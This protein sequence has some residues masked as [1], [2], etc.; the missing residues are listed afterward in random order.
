[1]AKQLK[2]TTVT[3]KHLPLTQVKADML[4]IGL[5]K[6]TKKLPKEFSS[7]DSAAGRVISNLLKLGDFTGKAQETAVLYTAGQLP[8]RRILIVGLGEEQS[9]QLNTLR[10]SAGTAARTSDKLGT[11]KIALA[12]HTLSKNK[13]DLSNVGQAVTEGIIIGHYDFDDYLPA[14]GKPTQ[15][16]KLTA[17]IVDAGTAAALKL[18]AGCKIGNITAQAQNFSRMIANKPGN[19]INPVTLTQQAK[20]IAA[21]TGLRC[22]IFDE[23][24]LAKMKMNALLAVGSGSIHKSRLIMLEHLGRHPA[25]I[26]DDVELD[27]VLPSD[28][29]KQHGP[30][31]LETVQR[32]GQ[33]VEDHLLD[34]LRI[35]RHNE[36]F[37]RFETNVPIAIATHVADHID[38]IIDQL[39]Q[40]NR[41]ASRILGT[42]EIE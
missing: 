4:V 28:Q 24:Q 15:N 2:K 7:L 37:F 30:A 3:A 6:D 26:V 17:T 5:Y 23:K 1:M 19:E 22:K 42:R 34:L 40:L 16:N 32:V 39:R 8:C 13:F 38:H 25:P 20:Q 9:L 21:K 12:L 41:L 33:Q 29:I 27:K 31:R 35:D 18:N 36:D 14:K 11:A 10:Q